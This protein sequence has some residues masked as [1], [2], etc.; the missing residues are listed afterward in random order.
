MIAGM[1][2]ARLM[3]AA[4][5]LLFAAPLATL[6]APALAGGDHL[7]LPHGQPHQTYAYGEPQGA[8]VHG[9]VHGAG[10]ENLRKR[11]H[12]WFRPRVQKIAD[13]EVVP[14][15]YM[16]RERVWLDRYTYTNRYH[17]HCD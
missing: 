11:P 9:Y 4:A 15:C 17:R 10:E 2:I 12:Y 1:T 7:P 5:A 16:K 13:K 14:S 3:R 8:P 6:A